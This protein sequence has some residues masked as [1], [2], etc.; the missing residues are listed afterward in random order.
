[1][2]ATP[3]RC[4]NLRLP[5]QGF[6]TGKLA[7]RR[8]SLSSGLFFCDC[9]GGHEARRPPERTG[10]RR[11]RSRPCEAE[12]PFHVHALHVSSGTGILASLA[13]P[14]P[15]RDPC[16]PTN[17][18]PALSQ[19]SVKLDPS[20]DNAD[21][22]DFRVPSLLSMVISSTLPPN[23]PIGPLARPTVAEQVPDTDV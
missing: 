23:E 19:A 1:M 8:H 4:G 12:R 5:A 13:P 18:G 15:S 16:R 21:G 20:F 7:V 9:S 22:C 3:R 10:S 11:R 6:P 2:A 17:Q 14:F